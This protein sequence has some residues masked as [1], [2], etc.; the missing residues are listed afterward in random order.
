MNTIQPAK[1]P[2]YFKL[3]MVL[4]SLIS[5]GYLSIMGKEILAPLMFSLL[6]A[7]LLLPVSV[8]LE[9]RLNLPRSAAAGLSV[10]LLLLAISIIVYLVGSQVSG[11]ARDWPMFEVQV[12]SSLTNLQNWISTTFHIDLKKQTDYIESSAS[13]LLN[14][15]TTVL[16]TTVIT[17][18]SLMLFLVFTLIDTF[19]LLLY[20]RLILKFLV[21]VFKEENARTLYEVIAE[22]QFIIRKYILGL[23][24]EMLIVAGACCIAFWLLDIKYAVLLG[25]ITGLF[26]IIPYIGIFSAL[27]LSTL[28]TFAAGATTGKILLVVITVVVMHLVDSNVL[29][30]LVVGSKVRINALITLLAVII[31]EMMWGITGMFLAIP[32]IAMAKIIFDRIEGLQ[33]WGVLLGA[34]KEDKK[35]LSRKY[36]VKK[37]IKTAP[38]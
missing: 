9:T 35:P 13:K 22:I 36:S 12:R 10:L 21:G 19:F 14:A 37:V 3:A 17:V 8:F 38:D 24:L 34:E 15:G 23:L 11:L 26:N 27:L 1:N 7:I 32:V 25:L 33:P 28:I 18:S 2:F 6:I 5:L 20:R 16:G 31:G 4:V 29:L 30:P